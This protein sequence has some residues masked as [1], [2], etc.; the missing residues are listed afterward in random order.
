MERVRGESTTLAASV[1]PTAMPKGFG[2]N[3]KRESMTLTLRQ[4]HHIDRL[5]ARYNARTMGSKL[6]T[7]R[8]RPHHAEPRTAAGFNRLWKEMVYPIVIERSQGCR[9][10]DVDGNS[11]IDILR[12]EEHTYE[13]QSL[14]RSAYAVFCLK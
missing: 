1:E 12:S 10:Q 2:P 5:T 11:Y 6:H 7:Q 9:L 14:M 3:V 4:R 8:H 13:L